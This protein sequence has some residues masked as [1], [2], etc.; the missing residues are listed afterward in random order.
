MRKIKFRWLD[1]KGFNYRTIILPRDAQQMLYVDTNGVEVYEGELVFDGEDQN[2][3][4]NVIFPAPRRQNSLDGVE[5]TRSYGDADWCGAKF[6]KHE[7]LYLT[8]G[9]V[10]QEQAAFL[11][12]KISRDARREWLYP[13]DSTDEDDREKSVFDL[14]PDI[15]ELRDVEEATP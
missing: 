4:E 6:I 13:C 3:A 12:D 9:I 14:L 5:L 7:P 8:E 1:S 11:H 15:S 10:I 2:F